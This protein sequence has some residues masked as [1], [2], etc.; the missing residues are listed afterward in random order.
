MKTKY[1]VLAIA[2]AGLSMTACNDLDTEPM[3]GTVTSDQKTEVIEERPEMAQAAVNAL[4]EGIKAYLANY[5]RFGALHTDFGVPSMNMMLD[6]RGTDMVSAALGNNWYTAALTMQDFGPRYYNNLLTWNTYYNMILSANNVALT[7]P[8]DAE[9]AQLKYYRA[10]AV[11]FRAFCYMQMVQLYAFTYKTN[12]NDGALPII[13][14]ANINEAAES[15]PLSTVAE[16][17][18][19]VKTDLD[20]AINLLEASA[21]GGFTNNNKRYISLATAY[22]LRARANLVTVDWANAAADAQKAI[23]LGK[24]NGLAPYSYE[25]ACQATGFVSRNDVNMMWSANME[26]T[27]DGATSTVISFASQ[28]GPWLSNG[29]TSIGNYRCINKKL[30]A[31]IP[32][33]DARKAWWLDGNKNAAATLPAVYTEFVK[34]ASSMGLVSADLLPYTTVKF[35]AP[36]NTPGG[37]VSYLDYPLMRVE[38]MYLILAEAQGMQ[39]AANG[40]ATLQSFVQ[41]YRN[42]SYTCTAASSEA[43]QEEVWFQRRLELWGEGFAYFDIMRLSKGIDRRGGGF[44]SEF[45]FNIPAG[46]PVLIF[47]I[48][49]TEQQGNPAIGNVTHGATVPSPVPDVE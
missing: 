39:N 19:Q 47:D 15:C 44:P 10:Q 38:E 13:T 33:G 1:K 14:D 16:V 18:A 6:S 25:R 31:Q 20:E 28:M 12:P 22:G 34:N 45:V 24:A 21:Q 4:P 29:Y 27:E 40:A 35:A 36:D 43:L 8:A 42:P 2:V 37:V 48:P 32:E 3:G 49:Q 41:T 7:I 26:S 9:D 46:D 17:W 5:N 30:Y 11:G 23:D